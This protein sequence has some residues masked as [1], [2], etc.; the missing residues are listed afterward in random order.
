MGSS[1][2]R[3]PAPARA[4]DPAPRQVV[5]FRVGDGDYAIDIMRLREV[6]TPA[7]VTPVPGSPSFVEGIIELRGDFLPVVDL[8]RRLLTGDPGSPGRFLIVVLEGRRVA[9]AVD[10]VSE[11]RRVDPGDFREAPPMA[12]GP[13]S[14]FFRSVLKADALV[15]L[16]VDLDQML[17]PAERDELAG[18][19]A[20]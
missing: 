3:D 17:A 11:V 12:I 9:L 19:D 8:R 7:P 16:V 20:G 18:F 13:S 10:E 2:P 5:C 6:V 4:A 15:A 1:D 14:R